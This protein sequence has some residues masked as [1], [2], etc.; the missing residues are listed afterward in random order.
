MAGTLVI[1]HTFG[2]D[3]G[4]EPLNLLDTVNT[5]VAFAINNLNNF[6]NSYLDSGVV[7]ALVVT[8]AVSQN[9]ALSPGLVLDVQVAVTTTAT[10]P[11]LNLN[12]LGPKNIVYEDGT[13]LVGALTAGGLYR[14]MYDGA[15]FR[16]LTKNLVVSAGTFLLTGT[17]F[18]GA[19]PTGAAVYLRIGFMVVLFIPAIGPATSNANTFTMTGV[20]PALQPA[21]LAFQTLSV[22]VLDNGVESMGSITISNGSGILTLAKN[23]LTAGW[24]AAG[25]KGAG[26]VPFV[27]LLN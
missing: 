8:T 23:A 5:D 3:A 22:G 15:E 12:G 11:T 24:T 4:P 1:P 10:T 14:F 26:V 16:L 6:S 19:A 27:Y 7:N 2:P 17:G 13:A 25:Q 20:P 18:S 9:V 21:T